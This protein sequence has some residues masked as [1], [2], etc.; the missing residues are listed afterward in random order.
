[1]AYLKQYDNMLRLAQQHQLFLASNGSFSYKEFNTEYGEAL[2]WAVE[3]Y[4]PPQPLPS[5]GLWHDFIYFKAEQSVWKYC[6][7]PRSPANLGPFPGIEP[8]DPR[9]PPVSAAGMAPRDMS[10][11]SRG[12]LHPSNR[13]PRPRDMTETPIG[14]H[15][16]TIMTAM[17]HPVTPS[18]RKDLFKSA[19]E[20]MSDPCPLQ[21]EVTAR[22]MT[23]GSLGTQFQSGTGLQIQRRIPATIAG[24]RITIGVR[25]Y[26][27]V[28]IVE[29]IDTRRGS[30]RGNLISDHKRSVEVHRS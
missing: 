2:D 8:L 13:S 25:V 15:M 18:I 1:M 29:A 20:P 21:D 16:R 22:H 5:S 17:A 19:E 11:D 26:I 30:A 24:H 28:A 3:T 14:R 12:P 9:G 7:G 27:H 4:Q 10:R 23:I 6:Y